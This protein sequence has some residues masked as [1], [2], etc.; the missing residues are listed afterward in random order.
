MSQPHFACKYYDHHGLCASHS[1]DRGVIL[2]GRVLL[3]VQSHPQ[4]RPGPQRV[5]IRLRDMIVAGDLPAGTRLIEID[6]AARF[7]VSRTPLREALLLLQ[8]E[9]YVVGNTGGQQSRLRVAP[10]TAEDARDIYY[11]RGEIEGLAA[12]RAAELPEAEHCKIAKSM[13]RLNRQLARAEA[14]PNADPNLLLK[15]NGAFTRIMC[16]RAAPDTATA[17]GS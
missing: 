17:R 15:L 16:A 2:H 10:L 1:L 11:L 3:W 9:G 12:A 7:G 4:I 14:A 6:F 8:R 13:R 5:Y